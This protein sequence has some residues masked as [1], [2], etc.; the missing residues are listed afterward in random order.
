M[1]DRL[2]YEHISDL[3]REAAA[4][5]AARGPVRRSVSRAHRATPP[6]SRRLGA[7]LRALATHRPAA[8]AGCDA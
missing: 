4:L 1:V 7:R 2:V 5:H 8:P 3:R 6:L